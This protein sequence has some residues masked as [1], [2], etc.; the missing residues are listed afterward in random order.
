MGIN[1]ILDLH[2]RAKTAGRK[3]SRSRE[4]F[5]QLQG[6][7]GKHFIG[8]VGPRGAGKT[9]LL[10]QYALKHENAFYLS[11]DTLEPGDD[12]WELVS[13]LVE[14]Y[15]AKTIL[16]DEIH[17]LPDANGLLKKIYDFLD[18]RV[19]FSSSVA[20]AM[21]SSA[22]DL[23]RRVKLLELRN[24][25]F[26][27]YVSFKLDIELPRLDFS[28]LEKGAWQV[29][30]MEAG[31]LFDNYLFKGGLLPFALE[32]PD[33]LSLLANI[34]EKVIAR[35]MPTVDKLSLQETVHIR[36][37][38]RF[39]G[40]SSV[41]GISYSSLSSN[42]GITKYK[43][44]Q[45][46]S[47]LEKAFLLHRIMPEGSNVLREPKI[48]MAPPLR[49]L[50]KQDDAAMGGIREDFFAEAMCSAG[51]EISY[52]KGTRGQKTPD[53]LLRDS[54]EKMVVEIGGK[55]KGREQFK[56]IK[57]DRKIVLAHTDIPVKG[58]IPLFMAGYLA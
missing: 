9:I 17:F 8:I 20:L 57:V 50:Y 46:V 23:S 15:N 1:S 28:D 10:Q 25:S 36:N 30:H 39:M 5:N 31:R 53:Y 16:I 41:D 52:L 11:A 13:A 33:A 18:V 32:E 54:K 51:I 47:S 19:I 27:E 38:L 58:K 55:R 21:H 2:S 49:L 40:L 37:I 29:G 7:K 45:Y 34:V 22:Y 3:Y 14:H 4:L 24:F 12:L 6:E 56:G 48:L 42:L 35:D 26:R 44:E 43:A